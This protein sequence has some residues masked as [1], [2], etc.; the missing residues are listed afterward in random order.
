[1]ITAERLQEV[2]YELPPAQTNPAP[3]YIC[4]YTAPHGEHCIIGEICQ[5][6]GLELPKL[7]DPDNKVAV[8]YLAID[9]RWTGLFT[10]SAVVWAAQAQLL[11]QMGYPWKVCMDS[12]NNSVAPIIKLNHESKCVSVA[13]ARGLQERFNKDVRPPPADHD[14]QLDMVK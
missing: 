10:P 14:D 6:L 9:G 2:G 7:D 5:R 3:G 13:A 11:G 8:G 1:M 4:L 12:A